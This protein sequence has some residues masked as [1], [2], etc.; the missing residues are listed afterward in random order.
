MALEAKPILQ[1]GSF[2]LEPAERKLLRD[3]NEVRLPPKAFDLLLALARNAGRLMEKDDL[4]KQVWPDS[5][6]EE[7]SLAQHVSLLRKA[8][9]DGENGTSYIETVPKSGYRF[10]ASMREVVLPTEAEP[11]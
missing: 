3:G 7:S 11:I 6:V 5:F 2:R 4:L 1:F 10:T 8:L 9:R